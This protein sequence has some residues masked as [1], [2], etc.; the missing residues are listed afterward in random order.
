MKRAV[1]LGVALAVVAAALSI[2]LVTAGGISGRSGRAAV[3][4]TGAADRSPHVRGSSLAAAGRVV[5]LAAPASAPLVGSLGAVAV[6]S[7]DGGELAYNTWLWAKPVDWQQSLGS[8]GIETGDVLGTPTLRVRD[9]R[10]GSDRALEP[11]TFSA[12]WRSDGALAYVR[13]V[14]ASYLANTPY[15]RDVVVRAGAAARPVVWSAAPGRF[16]V[17][18]WAGRSLIV[19]EQQPGGSPNLVLFTGPHESRPLAM[20]ASFVAVS[21]NGS[22]VLVAESYADSA[23]PALRELSVTDGTELARLPLSQIVDEVTH[24]PLTWID[25]PGH[26]LGDRVVMPA[27]SGLLVVRTSPS[28]LTAEQV[29]HVDSATQ[30]NGRLWEPRFED[31]SAHTIVTWSDLSGAQAGHSAQLVCDRFALTC[32]RGPAVPFSQA[33]RAVFDESGGDQ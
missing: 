11:G 19:A 10:A 20:N 4:R 26:W 15:L 6:P 24:A 30:P 8:Q 29:I 5:T 22:A 31:A 9:L 1:P 12:A 13:G 27:S 23:V 28:A 32:T 3:T 33:P 17:I 2:H 21:P 16:V 7:R 14:T 18:G 25:G